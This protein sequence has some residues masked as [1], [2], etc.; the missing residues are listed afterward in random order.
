M[1]QTALTYPVVVGPP[2]GTDRFIRSYSTTAGSPCS[3][4][5][6]QVCPPTGAIPSVFYTQKNK[7][8]NIA[9]LTKLKFHDAEGVTAQ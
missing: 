9:E 1:L 4:A 3:P 5:V 6:R 2:T 8:D 7:G